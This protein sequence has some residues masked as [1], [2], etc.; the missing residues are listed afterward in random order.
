M[1]KY[2]QL[3][4]VNCALFLFFMAS[5]EVDMLSH[6]S[7]S[8]VTQSVGIIINEPSS[9][10]IGTPRVFTSLSPG[11]TREWIPS[12]SEELKP[13]VG[14]NF[15]DPEEGLSFYKAYAT[16]SGFTSRKITTTR[17]KKTGV[18]AFQYVVCNK[19]GFKASRKPVVEAVEDKSDKA[20]STRR[21]MLT[22]VGCAQMC[23]KNINGSYVVTYFKEE[24]NHPLYTPGC[25]KFHKHGRKMSILHKKIIIDNSKV[26]IGPVKSFRIMKELTGSYDNVGASKQDFKKFQR[27]LKALIE[28]SDAQMFINNFQ[29][30]KL[31]WS[32]FFYD[33]ELDEEDQLCRAFWADPICRKNYALFGDMVSFDTTFST[34]RYN[35]IFGP[36]TGV[37][38]HK[39]CITFAA[40]LI[41]NEDIV[42]FEWVFKTFVKAMGGN[43]PLCLI[44]D[45]DPAMKVAF[46]KV[47]RSTEHR[48]CMWHIMK[49][50]PDKVCRDL[51]PDSDFLQKI[52]KAVWSEE[53]EPSEFE[54]RWAKVISEFKLENHDWLLQIYE[55]REMWIPAY[56]RDLFLCGIM[57][58]T[59]RSESENN[60]YT[61]F[62]N[63]HLTLVEFY[64][65]FE[66][67]LDAQRHTQ[68]E[69]DN[70]SKHKHPECKTRSA[71]EKFASEVY[72][73]TVFYEFQ[74]EVESTLFSCI[75]LCKSFERQGIPSRHMVWVWKAKHI[76]KIPDAY[77]LNRWSIMACKKPIFDLEG[78]ELE[79]CVQDVDRKRLLNDLWSE[80]HSCV[81]LAQGNELTLSALVDNLRSLRLDLESQS[82]IV[83]GLSG[84]VSSKAQDI[85]LLIGASV[86]SEILIKPPKVSKN[87]GTGVHVQGSGSDKRLKSDKEK[88]I[89]QS[90]KKKRLCKGCKKL[91]YHDIRNCPEKQ[92]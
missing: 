25:A 41:S 62:T 87:K 54:E 55:K 63:P 8:S 42:S 64:M 70:S 34:N 46:P 61:K 83:D 84:S 15:K 53:I 26:N 22:R 39:K 4:K 44:T 60:F 78:N 29:N 35:M 7:S 11:G 21:R 77:V 66:S 27:D 16:A 85:E 76:Q 17:R 31:L 81:S 69:N 49:K 88:A 30:K 89:E 18:M 82:S 71:I 2:Q 90:Q 52:C 20:R 33:Y 10:S 72:T 37:D 1:A 28:G 73:T 12:C 56:F 80:I 24:H 86:P 23:M 36:F 32:A 3:S 91:G 5:A 68:G 6:V 57:R 51:P 47:F 19:E 92:K 48:F 58:T 59:S 67:A 38:H 13:I 45:E 43:E 50:M 40:A 74:D 65:R 14:M 9:S 79:Q 75:C